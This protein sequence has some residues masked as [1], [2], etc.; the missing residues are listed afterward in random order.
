MTLPWPVA[1]VSRE[2]GCPAPM[3]DLFAQPQPM[4]RRAALRRLA[5]AGA[6]CAG[7]GTLGAM[8]AMSAGCAFRDT[9]SAALELWTVALSP[10]F[11]T[12]MHA[13]IGDFERSSGLRVRWVDVPY[14]AV[15]RKLM[16]AAAAG[17][18]PDVI[19]LADRTFA[20]FVGMG[21]LAD[22]TPYLDGPTLEAY[23]PGA[24]RL[25]RISGKLLALPWYLTTQSVMANT[26]LLRKGGLEAEGLPMRWSGLLAMGGAFKKRT[27]K[28]LMTLPLGFESDVP[29]ML[30]S[31]GKSPLVADGRGGLASA[32]AEPGILAAIEPWVRA[33][34]DGVLP[35]ECATGGTAHL[36]KLY[37][38]GDVGLINSGPN[39][40]KRIATDAPDV[41]RATAVRPPV[42]G[43]LG[44][45]HI[46]VMTLGV[47][48]QSKNKAA[49]AQLAAHLTSSAAQLGLCKL[50]VVLPSTRATLSDPMFAVPSDAGTGAG[51]EA[52]RGPVPPD[53]VEQRVGVARAACAAALVTG[54]AF[55]PSLE[56][57][58][59]LRRAFEDAFKRVLL[60][61]AD[62]GRSM[63][64]VD[65]QWRASLAEQ[66]GTPGALP[67][68]EA[69]WPGAAVGVGSLPEHGKEGAR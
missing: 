26:T 43:T 62:L 45:A 11:D 32:I 17:R 31:D 50:A 66:P 29:M 12:Y 37:S 56:C 48:S 64:E 68:T 58:P 61:G 60:D 59:D 41:F 49:A 5:G 6:A 63:L 57:W 40:L 18:A 22:L 53:R 39:F 16:A 38:E 30:L 2:V 52:E 7:L 23:L 36:N 21:A 34:R 44:R 10:F 8:S 9:P 15:D 65:R 24:L 42:T 4:T 67:T 54:E 19:N 3:S 69:I 13:Q 55:T 47:S 20:R 46:A 28:P 14:E 35:R 33:F 27:G 51:P 1:T 25:G